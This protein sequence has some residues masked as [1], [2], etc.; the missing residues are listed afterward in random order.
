VSFTYAVVDLVCNGDANGQITINASGGT[1]PYEYSYDG[2]L[3][4]EVGNIKTGLSGGDYTVVVRDANGCLATQLVSVYE[5][6]PIILSLTT[7]NISCGGLT[8]GS[9]D[10][11]ATGG[12]LP[13]QYR[14]DGGAWQPT[15]SFTGL[16]ANTYFVEVTDASG[17]ISGE[18]ATITEPPA[19][20]INNVTTVNPTCTTTG[21]ITVTA[22]GAPE[23]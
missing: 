22:S 7:S 18:I 3:T 11:S 9:I 6:A 13:Y 1:P 10:A 19:I 23:Y 12:T 8:D 16:T 20:L 4:F 17:C 5:P 15:G 2:G 21:S 14:I